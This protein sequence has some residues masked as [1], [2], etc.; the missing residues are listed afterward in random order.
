LEPGETWSDTVIP[1]GLAGTNDVTLEVSAVPPLDLER[2]LHYLITYPYGCLEQVTSSVFP[3]LY[4]SSLLKL[5]E[6]RKNE[7]QRNVQDGIHR[8]S[9][10]Q[11]PNGAFAYWPG[12]FYSAQAALRDNWSTSY[13]GHF[14]LEAKSIGYAVPDAMLSNWARYQRATAQTWSGSEHSESLDQAYRLYTLALAREPEIGAMNRM[15]EQVRLPT[16]ARWLLA[17]SYK[18]AGLTQAADDLAK[19]L[20]TAPEESADRE[21]IFGSTLRDSAIVLKSLVTLGRADEAKA[22]ADELSRSLVSARWYST[23]SSAYALMAMAHYVGLGQL[24]SYTF[25]YSVNGDSMATTVSAPMYSAA[26]AG[27]PDRGAQV[28]IHNTA[29]RRLFATLTTRGVPASGSDTAGAEGLSLEVEYRDEEGNLIDVARLP[30]GS[31]LIARIVVANTTAHRIDNIALA[32]LVPAGWEIHNERMEGLD[33]TGERDDSDTPRRHWWWDGSPGA[34]AANTEHVDI[35]D[36]RIY[37]HFSLKPQ[38]RLTFTTRLNA[39]YRGRFYLPSLA[40][41]AM[42]DASRFARTRGMWVE[43]VE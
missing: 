39:A 43:V 35:R 9:G 21:R 24:T 5:E 40:V 22:L 10:F 42:Y 29:S 17:A 11:L 19:N 41:E 14:L 27:F 4:L 26:L 37:R 20:S 31:D 18:L 2:R 38:E 8:L 33:A 3:Q 12:G 6:A 28:R 7:I 36:D 32:Q 1:H 16:A 25:T 15:R 23:Q 30:Q 34:T 13:A